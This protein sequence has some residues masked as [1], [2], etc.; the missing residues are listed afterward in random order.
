MKENKPKVEI[1]DH[2]LVQ[3]IERILGEDLDPIRDQM[4]LDLNEVSFVIS[5]NCTVPCKGVYKAIIKGFRLVTV[6]PFCTRK[7]PHK[8]KKIGKNSKRFR[9]LKSGSNYNINEDEY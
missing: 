3:Y 7:K 5:K 1:T 6:Y 2:A 9:E 8:T 4:M